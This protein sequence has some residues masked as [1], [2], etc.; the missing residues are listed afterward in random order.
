[1]KQTIALCMLLFAFAFVGCKSKHVSLNDIQVIGSHNSY[2]IAIERPLYDYLHTVEP[3]KIESLQYTHIS[4]EEQLSLGLRNLEL[5]VFY[6]PDGGHFS[7]P[8]GLEVVE[9]LGQEPLAFDVEEKLKQP[10]LKMFHIQDIDF[11]SH[12]LLFSDGLKALKKW[13]DNNPNHTPLIILINTKDQKVPQT[14]E[15]LVFDI[16]ALNALDHEIKSVIPVSQLLTPDAVRGDFESLEKA[17]LSKGW[18]SIKSLQGKFLFVLDEKEERIQNYLQGHESLRGRVLFVN[19]KEGNPEAG[20]RIV[21][22]PI[23]E[24]AYIKELVSKGYMVRTRADAGTKEARTNSYEKFEKAKASGA[25]VI[26]T[27]Y[28]MPSTL[29]DSDYKVIFEDGTYEKIKKK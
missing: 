23:K 20:F 27:D 22:N 29:F 26:S 21:N 4:L 18:P 1:M 15:P 16:S 17:V 7:N 11:R 28:Y 25:Q 12:Y 2:K 9:S 19:S 24:L 13:S 8:K 5:D 6:D 14:R 3:K 10:G